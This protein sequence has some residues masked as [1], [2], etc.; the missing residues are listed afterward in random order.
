MTGKV[1]SAVDKHT[2]GAQ[3]RYVSMWSRL[4]NHILAEGSCMRG[5]DQVCWYILDRLKAVGL[6]KCWSVDEALREPT[7]VSPGVRNMLSKLRFDVCILG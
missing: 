5:D 2:D 6:L 7:P 4:C 3:R 1:D